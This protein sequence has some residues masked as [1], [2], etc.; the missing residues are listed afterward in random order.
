M[1]GSVV[2]PGLVIG[3]ALISD[4]DCGACAG[5]AYGLAG[6]GAAVALV[7]PAAG[8]L[9]AGKPLTRG[10]AIRA[11]GLA[12]VAAG[13]KLYCFGCNDDH[14]AG[15]VVMALGALGFVFG[16]LVDIGDAPDNATEYNRE[17][18]VHAAIAPLVVRTP[19]GTRTG[20]AVVG[21]F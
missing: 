3:G 12:T 8:S 18:R 19:D 14:T 20:L 16:T 21:S 10:L 9:Y 1:I 4:R 2:G 5:M 11:L 7:G 13:A 6:T 15:T 17:H